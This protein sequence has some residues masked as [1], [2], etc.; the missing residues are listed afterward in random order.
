MKLRHA[1]ALASVG[2]YLMVPPPTFKN[3][4]WGTDLSVPISQWGIDTDGFFDSAVECTQERRTRR[5]NARADLKKAISEMGQSHFNKAMHTNS[6][7]AFGQVMPMMRVRQYSTA[8][9]VATD[10]PNLKK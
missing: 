9:C 3:G 6:Q 2:W 7:M 10:N 1:I 4:S 8:K 5:E